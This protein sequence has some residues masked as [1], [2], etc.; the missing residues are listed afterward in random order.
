MK[1]FIRGFVGV[2]GIGS[3]CVEVG[4]GWRWKLVSPWNAGC[5]EC[6]HIFVAVAKVRSREAWFSGS[7]KRVCWVVNSVWL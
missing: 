3:S 4:V 5:C 1:Y 7:Y 2:G 6:R